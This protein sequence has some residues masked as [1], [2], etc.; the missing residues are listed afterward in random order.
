[1][2]VCRLGKRKAS[3]QTAEAGHEV[4]HTKR[5]AVDASDHV[6]FAQTAVRPQSQPA[7]SV[8][9]ATIR[10]QDTDSRGQKRAAQNDVYHGVATNDSFQRPEAKRPVT[11]S[12]EQNGESACQ[13]CLS[14]MSLWL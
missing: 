1:M 5:A 10:G 14:M 13:H 9:D 3:E 2:D 8:L 11:S 12:Y 6:A 4:R 7:G